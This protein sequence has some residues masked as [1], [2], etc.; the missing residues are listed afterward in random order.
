MVGTPDRINFGNML[1]DGVAGVWANDEY[2]AFRERLASDRPL[3]IC[4]SCSLY[5]G[6]F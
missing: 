1:N 3:P 4:R 5:R 6:T 2:Q